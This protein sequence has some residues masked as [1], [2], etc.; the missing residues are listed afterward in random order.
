MLGADGF[1]RVKSQNMYRI[2]MYAQ[3]FKSFD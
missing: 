1:G 3:G 2:Q